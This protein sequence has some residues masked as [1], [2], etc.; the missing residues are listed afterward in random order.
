MR[1]EIKR[2]AIIFESQITFE[3]DYFKVTPVEL[4]LIQLCI[5]I[6]D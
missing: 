6:A 5:A 4:Q 3:I 2:E 1:E